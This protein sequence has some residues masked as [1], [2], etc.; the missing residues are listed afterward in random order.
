MLQDRLNYPT[1][2]AFGAGT[3]PETMKNTLWHTFVLFY[4]VQVLGL[5]GAMAGLAIA[6]ALA[7]NAII[8]PMIGSYSDNLAPSKL[9]RRQR[10][11]ALSAL[12][13]CISIVLLFAPPDWLDETGLFCWLVFWSI[14]CRTAI[15]T[16]TIPYFALNVELSRNPLERPIL[17]AARSIAGGVVH[18]VFPLVAFTIFFAATPEFPNGQLDR[19]AYL[20]FV[21]TMSI[22]SLIVMIWA[23][24][25]TNPR[26]MAIEGHMGTRHKP[27]RLSPKTVFRQVIDALRSTP[28][29]RFFVLLNVFIFV[30]LG[31]VSIYLLH[32]ST[33]YWRIPPASISYVAMATAP[34]GIIAPLFA[35]YYVPRFDK[36]RM[37]VTFIILYAAMVVLPILGPLAPA[38]PQPG[39]AM[40]V[41]TLVALKFL[42]GFF[43]A[44][45][46]TVMGTVVADIAD[47]LELNAGAPRPALLSSFTFF[48]S[49]AAG[50]VV[51]MSAGAFLDLIAFPVGMNPA[52][53]PAAMGAKLA[54]FSA[55]T[56]VVAMLG[57]VFFILRF[58]ISAAK[59]ARIN[60][61]LEARYAGAREKS[62]AKTTPAASHG[63]AA[64]VPAE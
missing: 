49:F 34:G 44:A 50:A 31:V 48:T 56:V 19:D 63:G 28:N 25:G 40:Q 52:L 4:F 12:P 7:W 1:R 22:V 2:I 18:I 11:M 36:K 29:V 30:C 32:L 46:L 16:Y 53:V 5:S 58:D 20:P 26:S 21:I 33:Y 57:V 8:D 38:F 61:Q 3:V 41:P 45:F 54:M 47:E 42:A 23:I 9:G 37:L 43:Y 39:N 55:A 24:L 15:S 10:M 6:I 14:I 35:R 59:Q 64:A 13:Y 51:N 27:T 62:A 17:T 60:E